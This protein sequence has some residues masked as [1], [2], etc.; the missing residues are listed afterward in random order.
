MVLFQVSELQLISSAVPVWGF[1]DKENGLCQ[2][3]IWFAAHAFWWALRIQTAP[4]TP[5][6]FIVYMDI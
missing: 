4:E 2:L 1:Q 3:R 5:P 6:L